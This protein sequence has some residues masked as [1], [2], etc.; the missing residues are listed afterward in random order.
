MPRTAVAF[1]FW[2]LLLI[3]KNI[4]LLTCLLC[5]NIQF[6]KHDGGGVAPLTGGDRMTLLEVIALLMLII[7]V[8]NLVIKLTKK[9]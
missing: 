2:A 8:I 3:W 6:S 4:L 7:A 1:A 5:D 9:K